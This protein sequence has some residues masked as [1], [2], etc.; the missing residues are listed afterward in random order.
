MTTKISRRQWL[1]R[2]SAALAGTMLAGYAKAGR[3]LA[4]PRYAGAPIRMMYNENPFGPSEVA[5]QAMI[6]AF[7][8]G[9]LYANDARRELQSLI[10]EQVGVPEDYVMLGCGSSEVLNIVGMQ[11]GIDQGEVLSA[12]PTFEALNRYVELLGGTVRR[13]PLNDQMDTDFEAMRKSFTGKTKL[14]YICNPNNPTGVPIPDSRLRP[15]CEEISKKAL[16]FVD[17][18]YFEYVGHPDYR[19]MIDLVRS[20]HNVIVS[21]TASKVHGLAGLRIGF[22][23][24]HPDLLKKLIPRLT[25]STNLIGVRAATAS[26][27]DAEFQQFSL[28]KNREGKEIVYRLLRETGHNFL[29][30]HTNFV[31]F[32]TGM[33]IQEFRR[34]M[35][36]RGLLVGRPFPPFLDW[37]RLSMA[38]PE[39]M[40]IFADAFRELVG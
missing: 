28:R 8:E 18:A 39:E 33:P 20:G 26:Y 11:C 35:R 23:I 19:S 12:Y 17:E 3:A 30:S 1:I 25:G 14:V 22:G 40:H 32:Q 31:F 37:C 16:V 24:A 29:E 9:N 2:S 13:V 34:E 36:Q 4:M 21:R 27:R 6:A 7:P 38:K 15:F 5:R 10:A